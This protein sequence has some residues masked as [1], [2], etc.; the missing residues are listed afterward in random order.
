[1]S[2]VDLTHARWRKSSY[3]SDANDANCVE[4]AL[5]DAT[6]AMRD[7]KNPGRAVL[8]VAS[9]GWGAFLA[10]VKNAQPSG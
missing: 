10:T 7:S 8:V 6:A 4:I 5:A 2:V 1:M 9:A 3:S